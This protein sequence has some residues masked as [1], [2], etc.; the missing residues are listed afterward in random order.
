[1]TEI[2]FEASICPL[3]VI[4]LLISSDILPLEIILDVASFTR[5]PPAINIKSLAVSITPPSLEKSFAS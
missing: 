2:D 3:F 4:L 5:A 1:M